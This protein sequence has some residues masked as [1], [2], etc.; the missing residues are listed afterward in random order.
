MKSFPN[1]LHR[2]IPATIAI[3]IIALLFITEKRWEPIELKAYDFRFQLIDKLG[4][5][6]TKST[7]KVVVVGIEER[8][9]IREKP[10]IFL[11][12]DMGRFIRMMGEYG[13]S[14][15]AIDIIP[16]HRQAEKLKKGILSLAGESVDKRYLKAIEATGDKLDISLL[17]PLLQVSEHIPVIQAYHGNLVPYYY[18]FTPF[19]KKLYL[20]DIVLTDT[21]SE[22]N[23]GVIRKQRMKP[24]NKESFAHAL[25]TKLT[26]RT[27]EENEV[28]LNYLL[29]KT[30]P[31]FNFVD[32]M[33]EKTGK[34]MFSGKAVI[35]GYISGYEDT[36]A[37]PLYKGIMP[38]WLL[39]G[40]R[41]SSDT[42]D[43]RLPGPLIHAIT[44][45]TMLTHT[46]LR[47]VS[48]FLHGIILFLLVMAALFVSIQFKP[49]HA[50]GGIFL[51]MAVFFVINLL[52]FSQ[53]YV[54]KLFPHILSPF[55]IC[56]FIYPYRYFL[57]DKNRKKLYKIFSYYIDK[58][59]LDTLLLKDPASLLKGERADVCILFLDIRDFTRLSLQLRAE[60][61]VG[62]LNTYFGKITE[63]IQSHKGFANKFIGDGV[64]A[65]FATGDNP[66]ASA[67]KSSLDIIRETQRFNDE[68]TVR[69]FIKEWNINIG[70]GIHYGTVVMGNVGSEKKMDFTIIGE[71]V[72]IAS[73][74][75]GLTKQA[76]VNLLI[77]EEACR[78]LQDGFPMEYVGEFSVKGVEKPVTVYT[79]KKNASNG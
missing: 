55:L 50:I 78:M 10:L 46:S 35:L 9:V 17:E 13:V 51:I 79:V 27:Y 64:L 7:G 43:K 40:Q 3:A 39:D 12:P 60:D 42:V 36:Y 18:S 71:P 23:D 22:K 29:G 74:I 69:D 67:V 75:E 32:V 53:G 65:F 5:G 73:R 61:M 28:W 77:S 33:N 15:I 44:V 25:Y 58:E 16:V 76:K 59:V 38:Q 14:T 62:F 20:A 6:S 30:I 56:A 1:Y 26:N 54:V 66:V 41:K 8:S 47:M 63:I 49:S 24:D 21:Y 2:I 72:N 70:I 19:M 31:F 57:E 48:F 52:F 37:T 4:M 45:E 11:Y 34:E 68:G